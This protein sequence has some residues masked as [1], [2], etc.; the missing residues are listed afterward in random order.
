MMNRWST[1]TKR[2]VVVVA[3]AL[4]ALVLVRAHE[5]LTPFV[6]AGVFAYVFS[7][8]VAT[9]QRRTGWRRW[10]VVGVLFLVL[11]LVVYGL[12]R[13]LV[14]V[15]ISQLVDLQRGLPMLINNVEQQVLA[16]LA[17]SGYESAAAG[18]FG[19]ANDI[20]QVVAENFIPVALGAFSAVLRVLVFVIALF[21]FVRDGPAMTASLRTLLPAAE[22]EELLRVWGRINAV[23]G[24]YVRGQVILI[25]IMWTAT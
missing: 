17:G 5:V 23:L 20:A 4:A 21:Y 1:T 25:G 19:Q 3:L 24:Q 9:A 15:V 7:P 16:A 6:W 22:R 12:A 10:I 13:L 2:A 11:G 18:V 14:P 8:I